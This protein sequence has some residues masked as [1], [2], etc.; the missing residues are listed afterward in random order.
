MW[1]RSCISCWRC[2]KKISFVPLIFGSN[3]NS[4]IVFHWMVIHSVLFSIRCRDA[5]LIMLT[6]LWVSPRK[7]C[8]VDNI[9]YREECMS[10][11]HVDDVEPYCRLRSKSQ[12]NSIKKLKWLAKLRQR[13]WRIALNF[14]EFILHRKLWLQEEEVQGE[15]EITDRRLPNFYFI[16]ILDPKESTRVR[17]WLTN[18]WI[19][20]VARNHIEIL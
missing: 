4:Q 16:V 1:Y 12:W 9:S 19:L 7:E 11:I 3:M 5:Q 10:N 15:G 8:W 14:A 13:H 6:L 18:F 17:H 20:K 2:F